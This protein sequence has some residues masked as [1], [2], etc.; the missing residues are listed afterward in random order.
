MYKEI[1]IH[2][3]K[4]VEVTRVILA[5]RFM[6]DLTKKYDEVLGLGLEHAM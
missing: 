4:A 6:V 5:H 3:A 2:N 1:T